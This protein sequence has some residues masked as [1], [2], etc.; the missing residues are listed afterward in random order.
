M[1]T[2]THTHPM[3]IHMILQF[4]LDK[5]ELHAKAVLL[6]QPEKNVIAVILEKDL[7]I[8]LVELNQFFTVTSKHHCT[9][10]NWAESQMLHIITYRLEEVTNIYT[11]VNRW[12]EDWNNMSSVGNSCCLNLQVIY[13][14]IE[15]WN[16]MSSV[17]NFLGDCYEPLGS[18]TRDFP[19]HLNNS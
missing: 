12:L 13:S 11:T 19:D 15:D 14:Q 4:F 10:A 7:G 17:G 3:W 9:S 1:H 6:N 18:I 5:W 8:L 2:H 16:N